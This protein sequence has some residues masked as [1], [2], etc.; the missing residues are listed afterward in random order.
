MR[1]SDVLDRWTILRM[2]ARLD[3]AAKKD[4]ETNFNPEVRH[5]VECLC[6]KGDLAKLFVA[7][8]ALAESNA[9]T[10]E[11]EAALRKEYDK[12]PS[13]NTRDELSYSEAGRRSFIVREHNARR[14]EAKK[15]IDRIFGDLPDNKVEHASQV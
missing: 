6:P 8:A 7:I 10:W 12:D 1:I 13:N 15:E 11:N 3:E 4:L 9:R 5:I 2:K 14:V